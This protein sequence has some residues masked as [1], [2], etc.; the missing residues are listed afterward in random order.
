MQVKLELLA[1][2][3]NMDIGIAAINCGADALYIAGPSFGAREAAGNSMDN[4]KQ[5]VDYAHRYSVKVYL[6]LNTI[7]Y[8]EEIAEAEKI[9]QQAYN[10][11]VDAII[12][13]DLG[14]LKANLP[15]IAI[16]AS[17]QTN[18]RSVEQAQFL[19]SLGFER[20]ILARELSLNQ[21]KQIKDSVGVEIEC[22]IHGALCVSYS[23]QCYM[24]EKIAG[25]SANRGSCMQ[26]CR[27][28]YDLEDS[29]GKKL[30]A[31]KP[32][33]SLKDLNLG[34]TVTDMAKAGVTSFKIEGR[35]KN[36]SYI[37]NIVR[38]YRAILDK[39]IAEN[40]TFTKSSYGF[41]EGGFIPN[42]EYTFNRGYTKLNINDE[43][44]A[45]NS[46][47]S[48]K[49]KGERVGLVTSVMKERSG[50]LVF[51]FKSS[52]KL[53][54][55]DGLFFVS[56][57]GI[58][59]GAR[60]GRVEGNRV[61]T[62]EQVEIEPGYVIYRNYNHLFEKEL[63]SN[64]PVRY[65]RSKIILSHK[66]NITTLDV[67]CEDGTK[68][69]LTRENSFEY[70]LNIELAKSSIINQLSKRSD[71]FKFEAAIADTSSIMFYP[72]A[73]LNSLRR[74]AANEL[75]LQKRRDSEIELKKIKNR[76]SFK[77]DEINLPKGVKTDYRLNS[78]N[79]LSALLYKEAGISKIEPAYEIAPPKEAELMRMKYC[80]KSELGICPNGLNSGEKRNYTEVKNITE[81]LYILN[82]D[83][84]FRLGFDCK[85]C[86]M[87]VYG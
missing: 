39:F 51:D 69:I 60:A 81:P 30:L 40:S 21:I 32:L 45:W 28:R 20:L 86:E 17:T 64:A 16:H 23:G 8:D 38:Y 2:A 14:L 43:R 56:P 82:Q 84:R 13:Q 27:L 66:E 41:L 77:A 48:A 73:Y 4:V 24:S 42:P 63:E 72:A 71:I 3:K 85:N 79:K 54:N 62:N 1:P 70:A 5:L 19:E 22:F 61:F 37:K 78:S 68:V 11:G 44:G 83:K 52:I 29:D 15:P 10:A 75:S 25:R 6:T 12:I 65:L 53:N 35:L 80:I 34:N 87:V 67:Q 46:G 7:I 36:E 57:D 50:N 33:L 47:D 26:A 58:E 31:N 76:L 55:G 74:D 18:I 9:A 59:K 49:G